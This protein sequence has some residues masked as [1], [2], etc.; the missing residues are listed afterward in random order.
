MLFRS[1]FD[2]GNIGEK[3][4]E[5]AGGSAEDAIKG[6]V[7]GVAGGNMNVSDEFNKLVQD[8]ITKVTGK[9]GNVAEAGDDK[10]TEAINSILVGLNLENVDKSQLVVAVKQGIEILKKSLNK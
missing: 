7:S 8:V 10:I 4:G 5:I 1:M 2:L 3:I 6:V 9:V